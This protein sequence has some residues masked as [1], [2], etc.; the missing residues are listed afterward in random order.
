VLGSGRLRRATVAG[1]LTAFLLLEALRVWLP[2]VLAPATG[3]DVGLEAALAVTAVGGLVI[4]AA[5]T[6]RSPATVWIA[7]VTALAAAR[8]G[9]V[10]ALGPWLVAAATLAVGAG[11][12]ALI[13]LAGSLDGE[14]GRAGRVGVIAGVAVT[15]AVHAA[16]RT[17]GLV[18]PRVPLT[19]VAAV[20]LAAVAVVLAAWVRPASS[21]GPG[22]GAATP[23]LLVGPIL[24]LA[25]AVTGNPGRLAMATGWGPQAV[26]AGVVAAQGAAVLAAVVGDRVG[27]RR[28][29]LTGGVLVL[30][31]TG[32]AFPASRPSVVAAVLATAV[33]LG[34][35]A[36]VEPAAHHGTAPRRRAGAGI[37]IAVILAACAAVALLAGVS[38]TGGEHLVALALAFLAA[39]VAV[40]AARRVTPTPA[41]GDL[42]RGLGWTTVGVTA[43]VAGAAVVAST[44]PTWLHDDPAALRDTPFLVD[45]SDVEAESG[46]APDLQGV[47]DDGGVPPIDPLPGHDDA[48]VRVATYNLTAGFGVDRRFSPQR[49]A[50]FLAPTRPDVVLLNEVDRGSLLTGGHD[51]FVLFAGE[52]DLSEAHFAPAAGLRGNAL[53]SRAPV[54][55]LSSRPLPGGP[56]TPRRSELTAVLALPEGDIAV[57]G[58]QLDS[59]TAA[60]RLPQARAVA[61]TVAQLHERDLPTVLLGELNAEP[62]AQELATFAPLLTDP[63]APSLATSPSARPEHRLH[64]ILLTPQLRG[65][66]VQRPRSDV[67]GHLPLV[68]SIARADLETEELP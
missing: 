21:E 62:D 4:A 40:A 42:R 23:W 36:G 37:G 22:G 49:Q 11:A 29:A 45:P 38:L 25:I 2:A 17:T 58:T 43:A 32:G 50:R 35:L 60:Q 52:L 31:G 20:G 63:L 47:P 5:M 9:M 19:L 18:W 59:A 46:Q 16:T 68:L 41:R 51:A 66:A 14:A 1:A 26:A 30:L 54:R 15:T 13:T 64:Y 44:P 27:V 33:G 6:R 28:A 67:A 56:R 57:V 53:L 7:A 34:L 61:A 55:E 8:V 48:A 12:V 10:V 65:S 39:G 3:E 24:I